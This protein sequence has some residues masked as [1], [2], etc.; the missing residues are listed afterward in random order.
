MVEINLSNVYQLLHYSQKCL[1]I[2]KSN[3]SWYGE[4]ERMRLRYILPVHCLVIRSTASRD[5]LLLGRLCGRESPPSGHVLLPCI[6]SPGLTQPYSLLKQTTVLLM[7]CLGKKHHLVLTANIK[8]GQYLFPALNVFCTS[9]RIIAFSS[10][11]KDGGMLLQLMGCPGSYTA[12]HSL[13]DVY[14]STPRAL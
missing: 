3:S 4:K 8:L 7:K 11:G 5:R 6:C 2:S 12:E 13:E 10:S 1:F 9:N 14:C